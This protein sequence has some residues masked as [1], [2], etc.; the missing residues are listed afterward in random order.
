MFPFI[1]ED[2]GFAIDDVNKKLVVSGVALA[3]AIAFESNQDLRKAR[4][5]GGRNEDVA[6][7]FLPARKVS[8]NESAGCQ[9]GVAPAHDVASEAK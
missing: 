5:H 9:Q 1:D 6:N 8:V 2:A 4:T 7:G 3:L